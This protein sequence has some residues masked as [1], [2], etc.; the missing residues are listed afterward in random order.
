MLTQDYY[1]GFGERVKKVKRELLRFLIDA[2]ERGK[3]VV[4]YGA[5]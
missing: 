1:R 5:P 4:G 2:K 3:K